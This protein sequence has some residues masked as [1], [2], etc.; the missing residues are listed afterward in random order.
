MKTGFKAVNF[1]GNISKGDLRQKKTRLNQRKSSGISR[2]LNS[3]MLKCFWV[4][5]FFSTKH[6]N[7]DLCKKVIRKI[8]SHIYLDNAM[9]TW[10]LFKWCLQI[11]WKTLVRS[12]GQDQSILLDDENQTFF[13]LGQESNTIAKYFEN[14]KFKLE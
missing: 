5:R 8:V 7:R 9:V 12:W 6:E 13:R 4:R 2:R 11:C 1:A 10:L 14:L 3:R